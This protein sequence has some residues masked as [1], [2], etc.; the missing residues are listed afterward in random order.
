MCD[1]TDVSILDS[2]IQEDRSS[3][4][5]DCCTQYPEESLE[6]CTASSYQPTLSFVSG[7]Q[8]ESLMLEISNMVSECI[9][10][11]NALRAELVSTLAKAKAR[12]ASGGK[13]SAL[14][15]MRRVHKIRKTISGLLST[16]C[17]LMEL[18]VQVQTEIQRFQPFHENESVMCDLE[19]E[20]F[21]SS[22]NA[23]RKTSNTDTLTPKDDSD[24]LKE[25]DQLL[26]GEKS[27]LVMVRSPQNS[28]ISPKV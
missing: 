16:R 10:Q 20:E 9:E 12:Y 3:C 27:S 2:E 23:L 17:S 11:K 26:V 13:V 7:S 8:V 24:Y 19:L 14:I 21:R 5:S 18:L 28:L 1:M 25:L 15:S 4:S 6:D 22:L